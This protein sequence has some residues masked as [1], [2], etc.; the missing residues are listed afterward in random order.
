MVEL[1]EAVVDRAADELGV[2]DAEA[3]AVVLDRADVVAVQPA[4]KPEA[5]LGERAA[6]AR[7]ADG[8]AEH[9]V[10]DASKPRLPA[11]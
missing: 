9:A 1:G 6:G 2:G 11:T 3:V 8:E 7:L 4:G 10:L 5:L